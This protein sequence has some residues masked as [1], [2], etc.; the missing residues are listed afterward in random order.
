MSV[1]A[2]Q[3]VY[4]VGVYQPLE[5]IIAMSNGGFNQTAA[6]A[7]HGVTPVVWVNREGTTLRLDIQGLEPVSLQAGENYS[8]IFQ[9]AGKY[10][11]S[12]YGFAAEGQVTVV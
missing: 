4:A 2:G 1:L 6:T 3:T 8:H 7:L 11:F 10:A 5:R 9:S 12:V